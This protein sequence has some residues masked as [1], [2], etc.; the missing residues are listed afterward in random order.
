MQMAAAVSSC[1]TKPSEKRSKNWMESEVFA[2]I[3]VWGEKIDDLR[4][5]KKNRMVY[6][7]IAKILREGGICRSARR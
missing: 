1:S 7:D 2:L 6:E 5:F 3:K 4:S